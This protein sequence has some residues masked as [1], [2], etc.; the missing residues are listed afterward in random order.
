MIDALSVSTASLEEGLKLA[1]DALAAVEQRVGADVDRANILGPDVAAAHEMS[2][3][4]ECH[5]RGVL[6]LVTDGRT[7][8]QERTA[9]ILVHGTTV[10]L[11][12]GD[13]RTLLWQIHLD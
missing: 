11:E 5:R 10:R 9:Y 7:L 1:L 12:H 4:C 2:H 13:T 8:Y 6:V 3:C